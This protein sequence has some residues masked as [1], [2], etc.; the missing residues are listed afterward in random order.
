VR[1]HFRVEQPEAV[2]GAHVAVDLR[3]LVDELDCVQGVRRKG[4]G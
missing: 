1:E 4:R 2:V 3:F